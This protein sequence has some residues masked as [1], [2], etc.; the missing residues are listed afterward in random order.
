MKKITLFVLLIT[1]IAFAD[2]LATRIAV[3]EKSKYDE[4]I[5]KNDANSKIPEK[6]LWVN[7]LWQNYIG[8]KPDC[9]QSG[10]FIHNEKTYRIFVTRRNKNFIYSIIDITD[11]KKEKLVSTGE[12]EL[13]KEVKAKID[14]EDPFVVVIRRGNYKLH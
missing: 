1:S 2:G 12:I 10:K 11:E 7:S 4:L 9:A 8:D 14:D 5:S 3:L 13:N 6:M